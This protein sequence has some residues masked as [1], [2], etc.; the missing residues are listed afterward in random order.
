[1]IKYIIGLLKNLFNPAVSIFSTIDSTSKVDKKARVY[2]KTKI[3]HSS[4][5]KY[6]YIGKNSALIYAEVGSYCSIAGGTYVGM[7]HHDLSNISTSPLFTE[8]KNGSGHSWTS[9]TPFPF[10]K[11]IVGNDVWIGERVIVMGGITIG[12]GAV[13]GAGAIVTKDVPPY[14]IVGGVPAKIIR[15]RFLPDVV[16]R[17]LQLQWWSMPE[18]KLKNN[19]HLFQ[20]PNFTLET[21]DLIKR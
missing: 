19:I 4:L 16:E 14:A 7:G 21:L 11:V 3:F 10:N 12:D 20:T 8:K 2:R 17:L 6:S 5:G 9:Q 18:E 15:Y 1:M 13:I